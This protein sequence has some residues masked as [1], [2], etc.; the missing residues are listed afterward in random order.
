MVATVS[1]GIVYVVQRDGPSGSSFRKGDRVTLVRSVDK[2]RKSGE[3]MHEDGRRVHCPYVNAEDLTKA[4]KK[5]LTKA[6]IKPG[7]VYEVLADQADGSSFMTGDRI[8][9]HP[10]RPGTLGFVREDGRTVTFPF[11]QAKYL[12]VAEKQEETKVPKKLTLSD[13]RHGVTYVTLIDGP[14]CS[15]F[16][17]GDR[18]RL[19]AGS[20]PNE[21]EFEHEDGRRVTGPYVNPMFLAI[22]DEKEVPVTKTL[23]NDDIRFGQVYVVLRDEPNSSS[24]KMGDRIK[25]RDA[26]S[27]KNG[28]FVYENGDRVPGPYVD[29]KYL[30]FADAKPAKLGEDDLR[31]GQVYVVLD[32]KP[33]C[34][35]FKKG[36]RVKLRAGTKPIDHHFVHEDGREVSCPYVGPWHL[37]LADGGKVFGEVVMPKKAT[38]ED[39][40]P[41]AIFK[42]EGMTG[43]HSFPLGSIVQH[44]GEF[45]D[46]VR[47]RM[48]LL[49]LDGG[50]LK[51]YVHLQDMSV[52]TEGK[53]AAVAPKPAKG[54]GKVV[55]T[56]TRSDDYTF[57]LRDCG[58]E[59]Y[60]LQAGCRWFTMAEAYKHWE[61]TRKGTDLGNETF[62]I[63]RLFDLHII[64][65]NAAKKKGA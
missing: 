54:A 64:R 23:T 51:Q 41:G 33:S 53:G 59:G 2:P 46:G 61:E 11:I 55:K 57:E 5:K 38:L 62:D 9:Q 3:F 22:A 30:A 17:K 35:D 1:H 6:D 44:T 56:A 60:M 24:F 31:H 48:Q 14:S 32:D 43:Y 50:G 37:A 39:L 10:D 15:S 16:K 12:K 36:D 49:T 45:S 20:R 18:I 52:V 34:S 25:L 13:L 4:R 65:L 42:V 7:V 29:A 58:A 19:R 47:P 27:N 21:A 40:K 26:T 8:K 28:P 63:L